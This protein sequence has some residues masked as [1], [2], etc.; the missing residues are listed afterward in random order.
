MDNFIINLNKFFSSLYEKK[1]QE[2]SEKHQVSMPYSAWNEFLG[3]CVFPDNMHEWLSAII[4]LMSSKSEEISTNN[5]KEK[6]G[7]IRDHLCDYIKL[8]TEMTVNIEGKD[9]KFR[10][11]YVMSGTETYNLRENRE[12]NKIKEILKYSRPKNNEPFDFQSL[13]GEEAGK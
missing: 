2:Y 3:Q 7:I 8:W 13:F 11:P 12:F 5:Q 10:P 1:R 4:F 6:E 9:I